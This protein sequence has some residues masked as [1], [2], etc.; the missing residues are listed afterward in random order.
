MA[1]LP[2]AEKGVRYENP[3]NIVLWKRGDL[4]L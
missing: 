2:L 3:T 4:C 1:H